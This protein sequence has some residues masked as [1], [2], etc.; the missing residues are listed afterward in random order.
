MSA[1]I[2]LINKIKRKTIN[3]NIILAGDFNTNPL[4]MSKMC[5]KLNLNI[6]N[7]NLPFTRS[8]K[9]KDNISQST[10]DY[11]LSNT[12]HLNWSFIKDKA[13]SDHYPIYGQVKINNI[14]KTRKAYK[15]FKILRYRNEENLIELLRTGWSY[16][17]IKLNQIKKLSTR[18]TIIRPKIYWKKTEKI[19]SLNLD[20][21]EKAEILK[22]LNKE[23]YLEFMHEINNQK[24][25]DPFLFYSLIKRVVQ[26]KNKNKIV[27]NLKEKE[28]IV[29]RKDSVILANEYFMNLYTW[30]DLIVPLCTNVPDYSIFLIRPSKESVSEKQ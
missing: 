12:I 17:L 14:S 8:Q 23:W 16:C 2:S 20:W 18:E 11:I 21:K 27:N 13:D 22:L 7:S 28:T 26:Y 24:D 29:N 19:L 10:L 4:I 15:I 1:C 25:W 3:A 30:P 9:L 5:D 6:L